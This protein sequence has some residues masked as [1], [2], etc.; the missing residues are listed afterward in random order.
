AR[1]IGISALT[2]ARGTLSMIGGCVALLVLVTA[3]VENDSRGGFLAF[4]GVVIYTLF[5]LKGVKPQW[6]MV[7]AVA[8]IGVL[9][10]SATGTYWERMRT[11]F[12]SK[13][14]YNRTS[15]TGRIE[16]WKRGMG[17]MFGHPI[18]GVGVDN[19]MTAEGRSEIIVERQ[20]RGQ[21]T[22]WSVAH[23]SWVQ[24]GA[25]MGIPGLIAVVGLFVM[26][27][28]RLRKLARLASSKGDMSSEAREAAGLGAA[29]MGVM[30]GLSISM[31][32]IT[33][34]FGYAPYASLGL[35][36]GLLKVARLHGLDTEV[37]NNRATL[38]RAGQRARVRPPLSAAGPVL[39]PP[40]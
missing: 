7:T 18:F 33:Q 20:A 24:A 37:R 19:F 13:D 9:A 35:V 17:Y 38:A 32:F 27:F 23:S 12:D 21:G 25:E 16:I 1:P 26:A 10:M 40:R 4:A 22:K 28:F 34:A 30:V 39:G 11:T 5:F 29:L 2:R 31:S 15:I 3:L 6:R 36:A 8:V 14:D